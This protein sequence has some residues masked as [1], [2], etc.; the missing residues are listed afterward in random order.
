MERYIIIIEIFQIKVHYIYVVYGM[1]KYILLACYQFIS[2]SS[3]SVSKYK[4][5]APDFNPSHLF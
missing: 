4:Q 5:H 3:D 2:H 1:H